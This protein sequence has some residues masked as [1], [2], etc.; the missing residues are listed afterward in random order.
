[1]IKMAGFL[2]DKTDGFSYAHD[3]RQVWTLTSLVLHDNPLSHTNTNH[4]HGFDSPFSQ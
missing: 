4:R 3:V 1:M 2:G